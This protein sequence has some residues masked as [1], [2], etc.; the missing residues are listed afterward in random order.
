MRTATPTWLGRA[1]VAG[2]ALA[3]IVAAAACGS[4][5][6]GPG[7][8]TTASGNASPIALSRCMR[9][10]GV[11]NF[12][13]PTAGPGGEGFNGIGRSIGGPNSLIVDGIT[14][15]GPALDRAEKACAS[16]LGPK[17]PPPA[18]SAAQKQRILHFA[19]CMRRNGVP[20]FPDPSFSPGEPP[21]PANVN[22]QSPAAEKAAQ[23]CGQGG[24][25][26]SFR[27]G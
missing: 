7:G 23:A 16:Y 22:L 11:P 20:N 12:P 6:A 3:V 8:A 13:D 18:P 19:A 10:N 26:I 17:G 5:A 14:F 15:S 25:R 2:G 21:L 27:I 4:T 1:G 24:G 9:A